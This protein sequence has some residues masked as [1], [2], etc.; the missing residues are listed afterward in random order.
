MVAPQTHLLLLLELRKYG[1]GMSP[2]SPR[3][4]SNLS[5]NPQPRRR[6]TFSPWRGAERHF[7]QS[8]SYFRQSPSYFRQ[9]PRYFRR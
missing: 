4:Y 1:M 6:P 2:F 9:L 3:F 7:R 8:P 5:H